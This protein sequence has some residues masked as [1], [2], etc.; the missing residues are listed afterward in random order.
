MLII[1]ADTPFTVAKLQELLKSG[2]APR[3]I[4]GDA[5]LWYVGRPVSAAITAETTTVHLESKREPTRIDVV[6][7]CGYFLEVLL[8]HHPPP[9]SCTMDFSAELDILYIWLCLLVFTLVPR[10]AFFTYCIDWVIHYN[11]KRQ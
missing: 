11:L 8:T 3:D 2:L 4:R 5:E 1:M 6:F 7:F 9:A 10:D